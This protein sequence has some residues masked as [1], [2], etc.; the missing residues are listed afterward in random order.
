MTVFGASAAAILFL[1]GPAL[2]DGPSGS[3]E[4]DVVCDGVSAAADGDASNPNEQSQGYARVDAGTG[5]VTVTCGDPEGDLD[6]THPG[7]TDG[8]GHC[9]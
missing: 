1:A 2:A 3:H 7:G 5:G 9:G 8:Q 6:S 4:E